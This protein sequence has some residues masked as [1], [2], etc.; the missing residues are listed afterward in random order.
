MTKR[1]G[2]QFKEPWSDTTTRR[3]SF[4]KV[5]EA[6]SKQKSNENLEKKNYCL[7]IETAPIADSPLKELMLKSIQLDDTFI[8]VTSDNLPVLKEQLQNKELIVELPDY[9]DVEPT[10]PPEKE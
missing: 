6:D 3:L 2:K 9:L 4:E 7:D 1:Q 10:L 5:V 8:P